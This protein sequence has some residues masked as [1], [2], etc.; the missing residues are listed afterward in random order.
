MPAAHFLPEARKISRSR[1][2]GCIF[3]RSPIVHV[4]AFRLVFGACPPA[5]QLA[6]EDIAVAEEVRI[7]TA[8]GD[9]D[10][11]SLRTKRFTVW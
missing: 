4:A 9:S 8:C 6:F 11:R 5:P 1:A 2:R 10:P 3:S 7:R